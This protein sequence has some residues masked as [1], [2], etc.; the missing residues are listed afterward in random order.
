MTKL[1]IPEPPLQVLRS[2]AVKLGLNEAIV[3]QQ[4]HYLSLR[5][6]GWV[7]KSIR[8]WH[9]DDFPFWGLATVKRTFVT[10][11]DRGLIVDEKAAAGMDQTL[12]YRV[13]YEALE[14][15][16]PLDQSD[17][18]HGINVSH[19]SSS[20]R[21]DASDQ[22]DPLS[23]REQSGT[24]DPPKPPKGQR[25]R[26]VRRYRTELETYAAEHFAELGSNGTD[27]VDQA[28]RAGCSTL[29]T[30]TAFVDRWW[31]SGSKG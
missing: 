10:L 7:E 5:N 13:D 31:R 6:A 20:E 27:A 24:T 28:V 11:R 29:P 14:A 1:L 21:S 19:S 30:V 4:V 12:R 8:E 15:L 18:M 16:L 23:N 25:Q 3:L 26:D 22:S 9:R 17:P 2:L